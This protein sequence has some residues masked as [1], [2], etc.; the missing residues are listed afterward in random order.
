MSGV[1]HGID[2]DVRFNH[3]AATTLATSC[4]NAATAIDNQAGPRAS[5]VSHAMTDFQGYYA[6]LFQQ[7]AT[8]QAGDA[9]RLA[10]ALRDVATKVDHLAGCAT[11]EQNRRQTARA[12]KQRQDARGF[13]D[14]VSDW[15]TGG[16]EPPVGGPD[17]VAP[18][19][20]PAPALPARQPLTGSG[21]TGT[22]SARPAN[23]RS[24]ATNSATANSELA[25][26]PGTLQGQ[27][28]TFVDGCGWGS[29]DASGV[30]T[31]YG[32][33]LTANEQDVAWANTVAGAFEA[34][35]DGVVTIPNAS[36]TASLQAAGVEAS[37]DDLVIDP[38]L[39]IGQPPTSGYADDPVN[40]ATGNFLE[41]EVDLRFAGGNESLVFRRMYNSLGARVGAF[42]PGWSSWTE[43]GLAFTD[44]DAR[45]TLDEGRELSFPRLGDGWGRA[46]T[47]P[48]WLERAGEGHLITDNAGG[49]WEFD[50]AGRLTR[51]GRGA[52][53]GVHLDW[54]GSRLVRLRHERGRSIAVDWAD[55]RVVA[56]VA[57][58]GRRVDYA[59]DGAGRLVSA[60][61][62]SGTRSYRWNE[63]GLVDQITDGD[64]VVE[65]LN[66]YDERGRVT[67]QRSPHGRESR[68]SYLP[69]RITVVADADGSRSNT[70]LHDERGR[71]IGAIDAHG[72]RQSTAYDAA[73]NPV[74]FTARDGR[75]TLVDHDDRSRM[76]TRV[77]PTGARMDFTHDDLD[78]LVSVTVE[79]GDTVG[80]TRYTYQGDSRHPSTVVDAEGHT[81]RLEWRGH[82][83]V[84]ATDATGVRSTLDYD[85]FGDL[86]AIEDAVGN[87][88]TLERDAAGRITAMTSPLGHRTTYTWAGER[89]SA[90]TDPDGAVWRFEYTAAGRPSTVVDPLGN[91]TTWEHD[92][93]G[94]AGTLT[95]PLGRRTTRVLDD[96]GN[97]AALELP[98]GSRWQY[99]HDALSRLVARTDP[100]GATW[101]WEH[102]VNGEV[103]RLTD[104][105][106]RAAQVTRSA[107]GSTTSTATVGGARPADVVVTDRVG[108]IVSVAQNGF[109]P[110]S[111]R[112]DRRGMP[113]E[114]VD[115]EGNVTAVGRDAAGRP[116]SLTRPDGAVTRYS[117]DERG[118]LA[119]TTLPTGDIYR[120]E[121]DADG[122]LVEQRDPTGATYRYRYDGCGRIV[123]TDKPGQGRA[124]W[125]YDLCGRVVAVRDRLWGLRR[126]S[127]D[128]AG[129]L[130][131]A[132]NAL[133]GVTR[134]TYD[135]LGR[136]V[137]I[138]HPGGGTWR[139]TYNALDK[140]TSQT[141]PRGFV[142]V[143]GYDGA[144]RVLFHQFPGGERIAFDY[145]A[146]GAIDSV[147]VG[148]ATVAQYSRDAATRTLTV[149]DGSDADRPTTHRLRWDARGNLEERA[150]GGRAVRW[151]WDRN[152]ACAAV[153]G[154]AGA[155]TRYTRDAAG[156]VV[157]VDD[158]LRGRVDLSRDGAGR[159]V[160]AS[161]P[162]ATQTWVYADG[163]V[164]GHS[165][166]TP[167]RREDTAVER[168][169]AGRITA[170]VRDGVR[171]SY[172]YDEA[173][174]LVLAEGGGQ[175]RTWV[176]DEAGRPALT[177]VDGTATAYTYGPGG[178][179]LTQET[180]GGVVSFTHDEAGRRTSQDGPDGRLDFTWGDFGWLAAI[181]GPQGR[182]EVFVDVLGE[183]ARIDDADVYWD[184]A[185]R[186]TTPL[187]VGDEPLAG[188]PG[189]VGGPQG[190]IASG[191][192]G[193]RADSADGWTTPLA[194]DLGGQVGLGA[195][196]ELM[197]DGL[198][199]LRH[200]V[201]DPATHGFLT[202]D[203]LDSGLATGWAGNPYSYAGNNPWHL[204]DPSGL[205]PLDDQALQTWIDTNCGN[206]WERHGD[207]ITQVAFA[208]LGLA[209]A[210]LIPPPFGLLASAGIAAVGDVVQ[211]TMSGQPYDPWS[212][213]FAF[214]TALIPGSFGTSLVTR[215]ASGA[216]IGAATN[217]ASAYA[218]GLI[219]GQMPTGEQVLNTAL[220]GAGT[221]A[222]SGGLDYLNSR[223][224]APE[225]SI[226]L[227]PAPP[228]WTRTDSGLLVPDVPN[229]SPG[230]LELPQAPSGWTATDS[231]LLVPSAPA[232]TTATPSGLIV[233]DAPSGYTTSPGGL[234]VPEGSVG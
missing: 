104:P 119:S 16:E 18:Q 61:G 39:M 115:P 204:L 146:D 208:G 180:E 159:L 92:A 82:L 213:V 116:I 46:T 56:A 97:L 55:D 29:L 215:V 71:L 223:P 209:A 140:V 200:R 158:E 65:V 113:V 81:T 76:T 26:R 179:L 145:T 196:G 9:T 120:F 17:P 21:A 63:A 19:S 226:E 15:F 2:E 73:G 90:R 36:I 74:M 52:G 87:R 148:T 50:A 212:T 188:A 162:D 142:Q 139:R 134:Y 14:H 191:W 210:F 96:I 43:T 173:G 181:S 190:W 183:L 136:A 6:Q 38:T 47:Q 68:F 118:R 185:Q 202:R 103:T 201:Y 137:E 80:T 23:L 143:A 156:R 189:F 176:Y 164:V 169:G 58:D 228:G 57:S 112:Y 222:V 70:W 144:G 107:D 7:N 155:T 216:A 4:R 62:P 157:A 101:R 178:Q 69:G 91:R 27:L 84:A 168:D 227:L 214:G 66:T 122:R 59:Y 199:W 49:R 79:N 111:T 167:G 30:M 95:D 133:G 171:T 109:G 8:T 150:R 221:G 98:D 128:A 88:A 77:L 54:A 94:D 225:P 218:L 211:Q 60:T 12:W 232:G 233:P 141:D 13:W 219:H 51:L 187:Q 135:P 198:E 83:P 117:Y 152:G 64:G 45:W 72:E 207:I 123:E 85:E 67:S 126:F 75:V 217:V 114:F 165:L 24:F 125:T 1:L 206:L 184:T 220:W 231:G 161:T 34:A 205:A 42:G 48:F 195:A 197:V 154:P 166:T 102:D 35:G 78:R 110:Y 172:G 182:S 131:A 25:P 175:R 147:S 121:H 170:L 22:S 41:P 11:A 224:T 28:Q 151:D 230:G 124:T 186:S 194:A 33:Y 229:V 86:V 89:L 163:D 193:V 10:A 37:R 3:A 20:V 53:T 31:A 40:T 192:R 44:E 174:Q 127:Y 32:Q 130:V 153:T 93:S 5:W 149:H 138:T 99:T 160:A 105:T 100:D 177:T 203:P 108:R 132:T 129:Q 234:Y 106:G